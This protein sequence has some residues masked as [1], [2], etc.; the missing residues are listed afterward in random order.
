M[1]FNIR[2]A[3]HEDFSSVLN[4]IQELADFEKE[5]DAVAI[6]VEEL[7]TDYSNGLFSCLIAEQDKNIIGMALYYNRYSTWKG[8]TIHLEDLIVTHEYRGSGVGKALLN[9][10]VWEAKNEGLRRVE[11]CVLDWNSTAIKFYES[12]GG[13]IF[14]R[15]VF[16]STR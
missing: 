16:S 4:L 2:K 6:S 11:W 7:Q 5:S 1:L 12:V 9:K 10:I 3:K 15:L 14:K 8:K 13:E